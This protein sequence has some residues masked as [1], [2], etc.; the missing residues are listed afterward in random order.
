MNDFVM[1]ATN[2]FNEALGNML[3][4]R[5][6]RQQYAELYL[7]NSSLLPAQYYGAEHLLR[8]F[9][10]LPGV[11][12]QAEIS[13]QD[14]VILKTYSQLLLEFLVK[15]HDEFFS[16]DYDYASPAHLNMTK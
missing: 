8:M 11:L 15:M 9:V 7:N 2:F 10:Q 12:A 6:E 1:G 14:L 3:L 13:L 5:L 16:A 4:Y